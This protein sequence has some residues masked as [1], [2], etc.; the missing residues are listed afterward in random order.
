MWVVGRTPVA[1]HTG[2]SS[3]PPSGRTSRDSVHGTRP[4]R[5]RSQVLEDGCV[6]CS[7]PCLR[8]PAH[9]RPLTPTLGWFVSVP[10]APGSR[11][12]GGRVPGC[13]RPYVILHSSLRRETSVSGAL[14]E[15]KERVV[16][17]VTPYLP[18]GCGRVPGRPWSSSSA[19][20]IP[21]STRLRRCFLVTGRRV[22]RGGRIPLPSRGDLKST[23]VGRFAQGAVHHDSRSCACPSSTSLLG[24]TPVVP[25]RTGLRGAPTWRLLPW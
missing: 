3:P 17:S 8:P 19:D 13:Q 23:M 2:P 5:R 20:R 1:P 6:A 25:T 22:D 15:R 24:W 11:R 16:T 14:S 9:P 4:V 10:Y 12:I 7:V 18:R 21:T